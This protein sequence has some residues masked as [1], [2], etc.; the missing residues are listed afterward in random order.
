MGFDISQVIS[1]DRHYS[2]FICTVCQ[3]LV[4]L[5]AVVTTP[6]SHPFCRECLE[7]WA[8]QCGEE[9][10]DCS[11]P[12]CQHNLSLSASETSM[13]RS[14]YA[15][16]RS[17]STASIQLGGMHVS[18]QPLET[19]QPLAYAVL[20]QVQVACIELSSQ[21][22]GW[23]GDYGD[24]RVHASG[25][26]DQAASNP[27]TETRTELLSPKLKR[28][29][30]SPS[31][32]PTLS[33]TGK[34]L[35][36]PNV[37]VPKPT[38]VGND[39]GRVGDSDD[40]DQTP[41]TQD[42]NARRVAFRQ[43]QSV[44]NLDST[45]Y[46]HPI[47][48]E[49]LKSSLLNPR[50]A[51]NGCISTD[52]VVPKTTIA[53]TRDAPP[54]LVKRTKS[55]DGNKVPSTSRHKSSEKT[56]KLSRESEDLEGS[57]AHSLNLSRDSLGDWNNSNSFGTNDDSPLSAAAMETVEEDQENEFELQMEPE[58]N[59]EGDEDEEHVVR[60]TVLLLEAG[61]KLKK[62]A[63]AKFN[64]GD[65]IAARLLYTEGI[66]VMESIFPSSRTECEL[67]SFLY[68]NR[69]VTFFREKKF[70][71][72]LED[73]EKAI[74][75]DPSYDKSWI[76][77]WRALMAMG[78]LDAGYTCLEMA[79]KTVGNSSRIEIELGK[80][81]QENE[82]I[83]DVRALLEKGEMSE[84][85]EKLK[86][87]MSSDNIGL[88]FLAA[89]ADC[90]LGHTE[91]ALEKVNR[92]LRFNPTHAEGLELRGYALFLSGETEKGAH[93]LHDVYILD[94]DNKEVRLKLSR[95]QKTHSAFSQGRSCVKRGRY[96]EAVDHFTNAMKESGE[97]PEG[98]R[99]F[100]ALRTERAEAWL[101]SKKFLEA[102]KDCQAVINV[103]TENATAWA[104]RSE[105]LVAMGKADEAK[106]E[107]ASIRRTWGRDNPTI[108][109][110]YRRVDF[111]LRVQKADDDLYNLVAQLQAGTL[112]RVVTKGDELRN[113][114][115]APERK[116][117]VKSERSRGAAATH[118]KPSTADGERVSPSKNRNGD[119]ERRSSAGR[120][121][122]Y[123]DEE[124]RS[125]SKSRG[126]ISRM[127]KRHN[128]GGIDP[129]AQ[130]SPPKRKS[131]FM[132]PPS[133]ED[134]T[135]EAD[136]LTARTPK[137]GL[138]PRTTSRPSVRR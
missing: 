115:R 43:S 114:P 65:F 12:A 11:C 138:E 73:C 33:D 58:D 34:S 25:H 79:A 71:N 91:S 1:D 68:S 131:A 127:Q 51:S 7:G 130:P 4:S 60:S 67:V 66:N 16:R 116:A 133:A 22:C 90:G 92:A 99:L 106:D 6:C 26:G 24:F 111:E 112:E 47:S 136:Q 113:S 8:T 14:R 36:L 50:W 85:K 5:D 69:A 137:L 81:R 9:E 108:D 95:C 31:K 40:K 59:A 21:P 56:Q 78:N 129:M 122:S 126:S 49:S 105:V 103:D 61:E 88:L 82:L 72:C 32:R 30:K 27:F 96:K 10:K 53:G 123:G 98:A 28:P 134:M 20:K 135:S 29:P 117:S 41:G 35:S 39:Q 94:K 119:G 89:R 107:L 44:R 100:S 63:N 70:D 75:Y 23:S 80:A 54:L 121:N 97:V 87:A 62:Q 55:D 118:R 46:D 48:L 77:K 128:S 83:T 52:P 15:S 124:R 76:R 18:A 101:L 42:N 13:S 19:A 109:E 38:P 86:H 37:V 64:K 93:L 102:L 132:P 125:S 57:Y 84:A 120:S 45:D 3:N 104:I 17:S 2:P 74:A 110:G